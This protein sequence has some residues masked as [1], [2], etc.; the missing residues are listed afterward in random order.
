MVKS[1]NQ[2]VFI[3]LKKIKFDSVRIYKVIKLF[4]LFDNNFIILNKEFKFKK[5]K[6]VEVYFVN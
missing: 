6:F 4:Y 5:I 3:F 1:I 2:I